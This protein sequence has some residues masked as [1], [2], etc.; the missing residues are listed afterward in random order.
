MFIKQI[1]NEDYQELMADINSNKYTLFYVALMTIIVAVSLA[2][3]ATELK[4]R[5][6]AEEALEKKKQILNSVSSIQDK[7]IVE[8]EY[9]KRIKELVVDAQGKPIEGVSAFDIEIKKEYRKPA[10]ERQMP[11]YIYTGDDNAKKYIIPL[12][13]NGLW[14]A[15]WG[16]VA[17]KGDLN[18]IA[19]TSFDHTGETPGLG[20]EITKDWFKSQFIGKKIQENGAFA[21]DILKGR[22]NAIEGKIHLVDGMSGATITG[23][24]V[25][26][27]IKKGYD[28]YQAYFK[29]VN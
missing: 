23:D 17:L 20:A 18:T 15:I 22:G 12:Y 27:M 14:D 9:S 26:D 16:F 11:V 5:Q 2:F 21:L 4:P 28:S 7:S 13:G 19:G 24:G 1:L 25:E 3:L 6:K 29:T 8:G 10:S